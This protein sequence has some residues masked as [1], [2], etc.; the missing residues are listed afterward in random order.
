M[1]TST[2]QTVIAHTKT[3]EE[4]EEIKG[5]LESRFAPVLTDKNSWG[6]HS[7]HVLGQNG[8]AIVLVGQSQAPTRARMADYLAGLE[9]GK[10]SE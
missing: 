2:T 6:I 10:L 9:D 7:A 1:N 3:F 5:L 4:A 8:F